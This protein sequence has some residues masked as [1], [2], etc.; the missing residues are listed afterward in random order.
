MSSHVTGAHAIV[1]L[2]TLLGHAL[3]ALLISGDTAPERLQEAHASGITLLHKPVK[4]DDLYRHPVALLAAK[5][6]G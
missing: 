1:A 5:S 4:P 2:R 6:S 3:P